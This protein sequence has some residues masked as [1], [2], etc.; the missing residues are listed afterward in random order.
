MKEKIIKVCFLIIKWISYLFKIIFQII[1]FYFVI[2]I[3]NILIVTNLTLT[4]STIYHKFMVFLNIFPNLIFQYLSLKVLT[5]Y[6]F[7]LFQ[8]SYI[9]KEN[10]IDI[11]S[12]ILLSSI[13]ELEQKQKINEENEN[14]AL[15]N[16]TE[17]NEKNSNET[18]EK[19]ENNKT[20]N[21]NNENNITNNEIQENNESKIYR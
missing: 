10:F 7:E 13:G 9:N 21:D 15:I 17:S 12:P 1:E 2:I 20:L 18:T 14:N 11:L 6:Y 5:V 16:K 19:N 8:F 3:T 4:S